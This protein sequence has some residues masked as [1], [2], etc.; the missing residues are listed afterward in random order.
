MNIPLRKAFADSLVIRFDIAFSRE[1]DNGYIFRIGRI[2]DENNIGGICL[3]MDSMGEEYQF[4]VIW[5]GHRFISDMSISRSDVVEGEWL[6]V[7]FV[8]TPKK[9]SVYLQIGRHGVGGTMDLQGTVNSILCLGKNEYRIDV[10]SFDMRNLS[11]KMDQKVAA[12]P[13]EEDSTTT[14]L[15]RKVLSVARTTLM[16]VRPLTGSTTVVR[17]TEENSKEALDG[18]VME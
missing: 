1:R 7:R 16:T 18:T 8:L 12:F 13:L 17:P 15:S 2:P 9:D 14:T 10:P 5:E 3:F 4:R 11:V 6:P